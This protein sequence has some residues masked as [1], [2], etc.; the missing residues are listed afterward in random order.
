MISASG[1]RQVFVASLDAC[2]YASDSLLRFQAFAS[3]VFGA[4]GI[5]WRGARQC[6]GLGTPKFGLLASINSRLAGWSGVFVPS[7]A[8]GSAVARSLVTTSLGSGP[9]R[10][11][12]G[13]SQ[14]RQEPSRLAQYRGVSLSRLTLRM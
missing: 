4:R 7:Y 12:V 6:A 1:A 8:G 10:N 13:V 14:R 9:I 2:S 11:M 3:V 5:F